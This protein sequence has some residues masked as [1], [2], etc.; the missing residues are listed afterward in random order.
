MSRIFLAAVAVAALSLAGQASAEMAQPKVVK[1]HN[2]NF[3]DPV[4]V[5][6]AT[7]AMARVR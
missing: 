1:T 7:M 6:S 2:V 3:S 5:T 4:A